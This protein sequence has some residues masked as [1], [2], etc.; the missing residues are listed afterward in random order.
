MKR[1]SIEFSIHSVESWRRHLKPVNA[2]ITK[3]VKVQHNP[4]HPMRKPF[5]SLCA[6][7]GGGEDKKRNR[8]DPSE[9]IGGLSEILIAARVGGR[10]SEIETKVSTVR[11]VLRSFFLSASTA[12]LITG[13]VLL[14]LLFLPKPKLDFRPAWVPI[15]YGVSSLGLRLSFKTP[16]PDWLVAH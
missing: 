6:R 7:F 9:P 16:I 4:M 13:P 10:S 2:F 8:P 5:R 3:S 15:L 14:L 1:K 11:Y 12:V